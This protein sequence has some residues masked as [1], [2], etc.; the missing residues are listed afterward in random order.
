MKLSE[1]KIKRANFRGNLEQSLGFGIRSQS[2]ELVARTRALW[3]EEAHEISNKFP[4]SC[5]FVATKPKRTVY[6]ILAHTSIKD[7]WSI[8]LTLYIYIYIASHELPLPHV[9]MCSI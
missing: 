2:R 5:L 8:L 7:L 1:K 4:E 3:P 9:Y 6:S